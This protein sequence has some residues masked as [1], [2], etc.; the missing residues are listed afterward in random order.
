MGFEALES[1]YDI[2]MGNYRGVYPR[3]V[4]P[5]FYGP[6]FDYWDYSI[7]QIAKYDIHSFLKAIMDTKTA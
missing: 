6:D 3:K 7:D 5:N 4:A 2:Y 1:G